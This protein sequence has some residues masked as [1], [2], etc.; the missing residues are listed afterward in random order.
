MHV[1]P[2]DILVQAD[3]VR[4]VRGVDDT[5]DR[6]CLLD[7]LPLHPQ[8]LGKPPALADGHE[9]EPRGRSLSVQLR[10]NHQILQD[11]LGGNT[12][13]IALDRR[14]AMRHLARV[15]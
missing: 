4:V 12:R 1:F 13:R 9:I 3:F 15:V 5:A 6:L 14:L 8:Q 7:L 10:L 11:A 2:G